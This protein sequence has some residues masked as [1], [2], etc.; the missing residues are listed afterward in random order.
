M[1]GWLD[2]PSQAIDLG[3]RLIKKWTG[4]RMSEIEFACW[5][6]II[7]S[8][9]DSLRI[10]CEKKYLNSSCELKIKGTSVSKVKVLF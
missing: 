5:I 3:L 9:Q 7:N 8:G 4:P 6:Y 1:S 2:C 10:I